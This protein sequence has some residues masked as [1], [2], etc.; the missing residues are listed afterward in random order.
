MLKYLI[1]QLDDTSVSFCHYNTEHTKKSLIPLAVLEE[2]LFWSMK[3]NLTVQFLYPDYELPAEYKEF[4]SRVFHVDIVSS[5]CEDLELRSKA[6]VI[7]FDSL[8]SI[9]DY[10][11]SSEQSY[12]F[13]C[14]LSELAENSTTISS[15][16]PNV[17]RLNIVVMDVPAF[18]KENQL[19]YRSFLM[20]ISHE[21]AKEYQ[22]MH[23]VQFNVLTDR[24]LL[25]NMNNCNAGVES[26]T[27]CRDGI[28][29]ICPAFYNDTSHSFSVGNL[30]DGL[31]IKNSHLYR[32]EHAPVCRICDAYQC[33]RCIWLN[34]KTTLEVNTPSHEQ[35]VMAHIERNASRSLLNH[36]RE[37]GQFLPGKEIPE[38]T[39]LDPFDKLINNSNE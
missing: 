26:I 13:R 4:I 25:D 24:F 28:F 39:Y 6:D 5:T 38:L 15:I 7:V 11:F 9:Q 12:V 16:L 10:P 17:N 2:A 36:I 23:A 3:E 27:L 1:I 35:C 8:F 14:S 18:T 21:I 30:K 32:I 22:R 33:R 37:I 19:K 20:N 31:D 29:Y 34:R